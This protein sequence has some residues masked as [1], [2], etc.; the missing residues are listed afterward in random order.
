[1][2]AGKAGDRYRVV[3]IDKR[4]AYYSQR[5]NLI[6]KIA[7]IVSDVDSV[8]FAEADGI[9][10]RFEFDGIYRYFSYVLVEPVQPDP[11]LA[12]WEQ[13]DQEED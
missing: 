7:T 9:G 10:L 13:Y 4:D 6:G 1:M 8:P 2:A 5:A 3:E 11:R 12:E